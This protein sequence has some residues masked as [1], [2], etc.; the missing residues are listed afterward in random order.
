MNKR[1]IDG[2]EK[3]AFTVIPSGVN[4]MGSLFGAIG[5]GSALAGAGLLHRAY[6]EKKFLEE[7]DKTLKDKLTSKGPLLGGIAGA[8]AGGAYGHSRMKKILEPARRVT[9]IFEKVSALKKDVSLRDHQKRAIQELEDNDGSLLAAHATGS[10]KTL[11]GIAG[12]E[13][14]KQDGKAKRAVVVVPA[15][16][17]ENFDINGV[18]KFTD[19]KV[20]VYGPKGEK[21]TLSVGDKSEADYNI[22]S[23]ELFREHGEQILEDT[24]ADTLIMDEVHRVRGTEGKTYNRFRELREKIKNAIT[25][26]GSLVNNEPNE[27]VPLLDI[28]Y[29]PGKH[30]LVDKKLFD[31]LFVRKDAKTVGIIKPKVYIEKNIKNAKQL[32]NH[33]K[34]K[35]SYLSHD[36]IGADLP[37]RVLEE[38]KIPMTQ[39]QQK[40]YDF[41][42]ADVDALTRWKI[43]NNI[44]VSQKEAKSA[45]SQSLQARQVSTD[46]SILDKTLKD[47]D[48]YEYSPKVKKVVDDLEEHLKTDTR[49]RSVIFGNLVNSQISPIEKALK[50]KG[51]KYDKF[52][53]MGQEGST[54]KQ[55]AQAVKDFNEGKNRTLLIS[56]A[57]A[58]GLDL[59]DATMMQMVEGHYNPERIQQAEARIRRLGALEDR[60][61]EERKI[62]VKRY[63]STPAPKKGLSKAIGGFAKA[64]GY[65]EGDTGIDEWIYS[66]AK[67]KDDLNTQFRSVLKTAPYFSKTASDPFGDFIDD[68]LLRSLGESLGQGLIGNP[69]SSLIKR[70]AKSDVEAGIKQRLLDKGHEGLTQK[71]HYPKVLAE[72]KLDEREIDAEMGMA[73]LTTGLG[74][75]AG[76]D[77]RA[78]KLTKPIAKAIKKVIPKLHSNPALARLISGGVAG[79]IIGA[80]SLPLGAYLGSKIKRE[81]VSGSGS[82]S[83]DLDIGIDRYYNKLKKKQERKYKASKNFV[84]AVDT[85]EELG[86]DDLVI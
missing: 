23:Y 7:K 35:V 9:Q 65:S 79:G 1:F 57:G 78:K 72:S 13:K 82:A 77:P 3:R 52:I 22:I 46:P 48:P 55:R 80:G 44:P 84:Q 67:R 83:G 51:I 43:R 69:V 70:R 30:K 85:R 25:L 81:A 31:N 5:G 17:R 14:L 11:T 61:L 18:K 24:G 40:L 39:H 86:I 21:K 66:I 28:T 60:P 33:L 16:L 19:S 74:T 37:D 71:K 68:N 54:A 6:K 15:G 64:V 76:L 58:E 27:V 56:G 63:L 12:F 62:Q 26:T 20:A 42:M 4:H 73:A 8:I 41:A 47:K 59:K 49:N 34:G 10:G 75:L 50:N 53:G 45:F 36:D 38:V 29:G 32:G 2:F